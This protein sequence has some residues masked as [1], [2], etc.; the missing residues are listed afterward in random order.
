MPRNRSRLVVRGHMESR[1]MSIALWL[2]AAPFERWDN[3]LE[4]HYCRWA[5][6]MHLQKCAKKL[7]PYSHSGDLIGLSDS[8]TTHAH[9]SSVLTG[10]AA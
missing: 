1:Q 4:G 6:L 7:K 5:G 10:A 8:G 9:A 3:H 2:F